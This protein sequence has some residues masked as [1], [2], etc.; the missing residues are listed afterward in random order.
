MR[1]KSAAIRY[2]DKIYTGKSHSEIGIKMV[3]DGICK[4]PYPFGDDQGFITECGKYVRRAPALMIAVRAGQ[5]KLG[6]TL[7]KNELFSEDLKGDNI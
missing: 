2:K 7:N 6:T 3:R 1:I 4:S 5:V